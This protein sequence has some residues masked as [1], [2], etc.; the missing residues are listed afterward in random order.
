MFLDLP[1]SPACTI[2]APARRVRAGAP[3][4]VASGV[5]IRTWTDPDGAPWECRR[6]TLPTGAVVFCHNIPRKAA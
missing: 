6:Y 2:P 1:C 5:V 4:A 3:T